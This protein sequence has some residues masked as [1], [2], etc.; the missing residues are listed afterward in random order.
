VWLVALKD[1]FSRF[2]KDKEIKVVINTAATPH[3]EK[4]EKAIHITKTADSNINKQKEGSKNI[5][6]PSTSSGE[7]YSYLYELINDYK[8]EEINLTLTEQ[9]RFFNEEK[10]KLGKITN[11]INVYNRYLNKISKLAPLSKSAD[12]K[13]VPELL[14]MDLST[15]LPM[16]KNDLTLFISEYEKANKN[17][18]RVSYNARIGLQGE[19]IV[20]KELDLYRD[21]ITALSTIRL[22]LEGI[23]VE[24]D[25]IVI[26]ENGVFCLEVKNLGAYKG[27]KIVVT[28]DGLWKRYSNEGEAMD[29]EDI[30]NQ[31]YRHIGITQRFVN[32]QLQVKYPDMKYI[33]FQ[34]IIVFANDHIT[35]ENNSDMVILRV[36]SLYHYISRF[37]AKSKLDRKYWKDIEDILISNN[38]GAKSYPVKKCSDKI[39]LNYRLLYNKL[40]TFDEIDKKFNLENLLQNSVF[41]ENSDLM[42]YFEGYK[43]ST[44]S[45]EKKVGHIQII[46]L[47]ALIDELYL[48]NR[49]TDRGV[50]EAMILKAFN[51]NGL[52]ELTLSQHEY[53]NNGFNQE[54]RGR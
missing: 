21:K 27:G 22:E 42:K 38:K 19:S 29:I 16:L 26:S 3:E 48:K 41:S 47:R 28:K 8:Y 6:T 31:V 12:F 20:D 7:D 44:G 35:I 40:R 45:D 11:G 36:S 43:A 37:E 1:L 52:K 17:A 39:T 50:Y 23:T 25:S 49:N 24:S 32:S 30:T 4:L 34:P 46:S 5:N 10:D 53:I 13:K 9:R 14:P 2:K 15:T 51:V 54:L 33:D 18:R